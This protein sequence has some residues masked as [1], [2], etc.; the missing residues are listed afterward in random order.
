MINP[1]R[2]VLLTLIT[3][4]LAT[5]ASLP[6]YAKGKPIKIEAADPDFAEQGET[7]KPMKL[8]GSS[9]PGQ[10]DVYFLFNNT[11]DPDDPNNGTNGGVV[12]TGPGSL[13]TATGEFEFSINVDVAAVLGDYD[14]EVRE[15]STGRKGKGTTL[16]RVNQQGG[17]NPRSCRVIVKPRKLSRWSKRSMR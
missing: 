3:V 15:A 4:V 6:A 17:G 5:T 16:F 13:N 8:I 2:I 11:N 10:G 1:L 7:G 12:A 14:I 9:F